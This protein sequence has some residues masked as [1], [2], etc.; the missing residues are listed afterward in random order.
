MPKVKPTPE[1]KDQPLRDNGV[2]KLVDKGSIL[3]APQFP[4]DTI[5]FLLAGLGASFLKVRVENETVV[6]PL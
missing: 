4:V 1:A 6:V 3:M 5:I 2:E